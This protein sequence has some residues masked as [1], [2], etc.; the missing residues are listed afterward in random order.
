MQKDD[1]TNCPFCDG[2]TEPDKDRPGCQFCPKCQGPVIFAG[3][4]EECMEVL[5]VESD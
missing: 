1:T 4:V 2:P 3:T 5:N